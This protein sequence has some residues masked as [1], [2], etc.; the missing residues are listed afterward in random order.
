M[1]RIY[2]K[3]RL[4]A[5]LWSYHGHYLQLYSPYTRSQNTPPAHVHPP[6]Q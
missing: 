6:K 1:S 3:V 2:G 5:K 4:S